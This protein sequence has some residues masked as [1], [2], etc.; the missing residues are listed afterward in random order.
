MVLSSP[1]TQPRPKTPPPAFETEGTKPTNELS[2]LVRTVGEQVAGNYVEQGPIV[3][4]DHEIAQ[5]KI[6]EEANKRRRMQELNTELIKEI[7]KG[8]QELEAR[9]QQEMQANPKSSLVST[10]AGKGKTSWKDRAFSAMGIKRGKKTA[11]LADKSQTRE[12]ART[13]SQ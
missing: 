6:N 1:T 13:P 3:S 2:E 7:K 11:S 5:L 12:I 8:K 9:K 4:P 10:E